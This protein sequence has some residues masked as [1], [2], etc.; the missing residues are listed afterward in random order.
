MICKNCMFVKEQ[1]FYIKFVL[2][3]LCLYLGKYRQRQYIICI[4]KNLKT[5]EEST[6]YDD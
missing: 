4:V 6:I 3:Y 2:R 5:P 1:L